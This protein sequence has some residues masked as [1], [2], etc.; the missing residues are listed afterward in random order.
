MNQHKNKE[1]GNKGEKLA[2]Y[3]L[4]GNG[5]KILESNYRYKRAEIDLIGLK[6]S[7][8]VFFEVKVRS[9]NAFGYPE[10]AVSEAKAKR[11]IMAAEHFMENRS[12]DKNIRFDIIA[13]TLNPELELVHLEDA[14]Y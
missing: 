5:Y 1:I 6:D 8:I 12:W 10:Q 7:T 3:Y 13:I 14:F 11:I 4:M 2:S 9:N